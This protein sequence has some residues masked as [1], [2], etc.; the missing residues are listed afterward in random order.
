MTS[1]DWITFDFLQNILRRDLNDETAKLE[2]Y[3]VSPALMK[4]ENY[5]SDILKISIDY[6]CNEVKLR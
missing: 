2:Y 1:Y 5:S 4:G 3:T 6:L